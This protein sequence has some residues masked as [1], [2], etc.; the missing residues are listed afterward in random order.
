[1]EKAKK[2]ED[3]DGYIGERKKNDE[4]GIMA[5]KRIRREERNNQE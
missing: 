2:K 4:R 3:K 1:M 5:K